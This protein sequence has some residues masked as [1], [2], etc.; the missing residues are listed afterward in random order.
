MTRQKFLAFY[1]DHE[2]RI[3]ELGEHYWGGSCELRWPGKRW[4]VWTDPT[5]DSAKHSALATARNMLTDLPVLNEVA[6]RDL[7][8]LTDEKWTR[9]LTERDHPGYPEQPRPA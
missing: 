8:D 2:L 6:W 9:S 7:S 5:L 4:E 3:E 1:H